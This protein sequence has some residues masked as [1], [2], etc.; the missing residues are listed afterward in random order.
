M[1]NAEAL[2]LQDGVVDVQFEDV[3]EELSKLHSSLPLETYF[4]VVEEFVDQ[5]R[6]TVESI[7]DADERDRMRAHYSRVIET[8]VNLAV[9][10]E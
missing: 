4:Q 9:G 2:I 6:D 1:R 10:L 7:A 5:A 3:V 8:A